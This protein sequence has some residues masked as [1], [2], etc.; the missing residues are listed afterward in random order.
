M[1]IT[2]NHSLTVLLAGMMADP[3]VLVDLTVKGISLDSR[4]IDVGS[5]FLSLA[6]DASQ[7]QGNLQQALAA[8]CAVVLFDIEQTLTEQ[9]KQLL[10]HADVAAYPIKRLAAKAGE[11]AARFYGH[12]SLAL[13]IIAVTGTNGKTSVS[14]F[15]AQSLESL[16][17]ACG[18]IGTLGM[19]RI[20]DLNYTGMTTPDPV[21]VQKTLAD[22]CKQGIKYAVIEASS[23]ALAQGRLNS[24][25]ID[26]ATLTNLSRDHLDYHGDMATYAAAKSQLFDITSIK[27]AVLNSAD[28][29][30]Q[31]LITTLAERNTISVVTYSSSQ[32]ESVTIQADHIEMTHAGLSFE[33][34]SEFGSETINSE[35]VGRFNVDN[36]LA[37]VASLLAVGM[38]F[39]QVM[40]AVNKCQSVDGRMQSYGDDNQTQIVIDFAHTPDALTQALI[41]LQAHNS[42]NGDLWCVFGCGGD[43]DTGKRA[44]MGKAAHQYADKVVITDDNP[45]SE[46]PALIVKDILSGI[47]QPEA[48]L[49][50]HDRKLAITHAIKQ[51]KSNDIVLIAGKGHEQY[52]EVDGIKHSFSD[53]QVVTDVLHAANDDSTTSVGETA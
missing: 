21:S 35:L 34:V 30:G 10:Q 7:R 36:L 33:L 47:S 11:L 37:T 38:S 51:A 52:Q 42:A 32:T 39:E 44:L 41:S 22:F 2:H 43:R 14:Q 28:S 18:V 27:T 13:T 53:S 12:P 25:A 6:K 9:E 5:V 3:S 46:D 20:T 31:Q 15:I 8:K 23:H 50:E 24:I 4:D 1:I 40:T 19:G 29:L 17:H 49:I 45:R 48:V 26:V 16:G